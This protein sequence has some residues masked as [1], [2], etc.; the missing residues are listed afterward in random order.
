MACWQQAK[1]LY[2][3]KGSRHTRTHTHTPPDELNQSSGT[4]QLRIGGKDKTLDVQSKRIPPKKFAQ[5]MCL[6]RK[7]P[8][9]PPLGPFFKKGGGVQ[10]PPRYRISQKSPPPPLILAVGCCPSPKVGRM[11]AATVLGRP[12]AWHSGETV[13]YSAAGPTTYRS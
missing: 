13:L 1:M 7:T 12:V 5:M 4:A 9:K 10:N 6:R 3:Y 2:K 8:L 11:A